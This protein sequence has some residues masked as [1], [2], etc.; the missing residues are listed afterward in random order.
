[1]ISRIN[2]LKI[3]PRLILCFAVI[4]LLMFV[5][6]TLLVWQ[7]FLVNQQS[8]RVTALARE[9]A[10]VS[11]FQSDI[12]SVDARLDLLAKSEDVDA[13]RR[14]AGS[15]RSILAADSESVRDALAHLPSDMPRDV[16]VLPTVEAIKITLPPQLDAV[17]ALGLASDWDAVRLRLA[18]EKAPLEA[19]TS[20]LVRN[21]QR[22][23]S[24]ELAQSVVQHER[25]KRRILVIVPSIA[26]VT[27]L[28]STF[29]IVVVTSSISDPL[30][31]LMR[32]STALAR[33]DFDHQVPLS[34]NDELAHLGAVFN[35][36]TTRLRDLY[37]QIRSNEAH[38][39]EAQRLTHMGSWVWQVADRNALHLSDEWYRIYGFDP[40]AGM[41][42]WEERLQRVHPDDRGKWQGTTERAIEE[43]SDYDVEF[44]VLLPDGTLKWIRT[45]DHPVLSPAGELVQFVGSSMDIT[46]R[47]HAEEEL[48]Q[49]VDFVRHI[50]T[51]LSPNGKI[52]YA[53]RV[54]REYTGLTIDEYRS[55][56]VLARVIHPD[57]IERMRAVRERGLSAN[58]PFEIEARTLGKDGLCRWFLYR[59]NPLRDEHGQ[60]TRWYVAGT[61]IEDRKRAEERLQQENIALR[62]EIGRASMFEEIVGTSKPLK[63]VLRQTA[64]VAPT[65]STVLITGETGT[66]KELIAQVVHKRSQRSEHAFI[67]VNCAAFAPSLIS[68]E[69]FG[70]EKGAFTGA[71]QRR[72]GRFELADGGTIFLDEVGELP[73]DTQVA[74]LRILQEREFERVG[75]TQSIKVDVRVIAA[76]NRDLDAAVAGGSFRSDLFYRLQVFP[77]QIPPLRERRDDIPLLV[78]YFIDRYARKAGKNIRHVSQETL[79]LL[80]SYAWPGNIRELQNVIERSVI[81]CETETF[82]IDESWLPQ[83][84]QPFLTAKPKNQI[85][86]S[87]KLEE[88][89]KD[90]IEEALKASRGRVFGPTG[91]AV[92]LGI[93]RSTLESKIKSLKIDKNRFRTL[94]EI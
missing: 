66:G 75:G 6:N 83:Q 54:A 53:N 25:L 20:E 60:I 10:A 76:T 12:L 77:I 62:Q 65:D 84:P 49:L 33:G 52:T 9:L 85:E 73:P 27:L 72:L 2:Q 16:A 74:L 93:P 13:L 94:S 32:G 59:Y 15:L 45:V 90:M 14:E 86:L 67:S 39:A 81:L 79:E 48:Q 82:S 58:S 42:P 26:L 92:R 70:H 41:P 64:K 18:N 47:K 89:E 38:L 30:R 91:A 31:Q 88:Q 57:D 19:S 1:M 4:V 17:I 55:V 24:D 63:A 11:R 7:F 51:V 37:R 61:D 69:L 29:L 80:Q 35:E 43:K 71:T 68:S 22:Q 56:D 8:G 78:E 21:V 36:T 44:R 50:I 3:G 40:R 28:A 23:V 46:E 34:G 87:R 5:G